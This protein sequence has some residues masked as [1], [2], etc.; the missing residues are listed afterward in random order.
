[1]DEMKMV[2]MV[3]M[4]QEK[5]MPENQVEDALCS[6]WE[7]TESGPT[8]LEL[9]AELKEAGISIPRGATKSEMLALLPSAKG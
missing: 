6:G 5:D 8:V 3:R 1:M 2:P 7:Y 4:G 9:K